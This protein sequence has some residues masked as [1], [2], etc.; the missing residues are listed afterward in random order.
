[1]HLK[2]DNPV[3]GI[4]FFN[5]K[6]FQKKRFLNTEEKT[7][8]LLTLSRQMKDIVFFALKTGLRLSEII[9]LEWNDI[10]LENSDIFVRAGNEDDN[11]HIPIFP[12]LKEPLK[13]FPKIGKYVFCYSDST[14]LSVNGFIVTEF[15]KKT[16]ELGINGPNTQRRD[17]VTFHTL[18]HTFASDFVMNG[19]DFKTLG[20][21]MGHATQTMTERYA[22]LS[23][24][25]KKEGIK[26]L[27]TEPAYTNPV[28][29]LIQVREKESET[30]AATYY[31]QIREKRKSSLNKVT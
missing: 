5:E 6:K 27:P 19:G 25:H 13:R 22:H 8:L 15:K 16:I 29:T 20:E 11:R 14:K 7:K 31:A 2:L 24:K 26:L 4:K 18:R 10:D 12:E 3:I 28:E 30:K 9:N 1:M 17:R 23:P 21:Y